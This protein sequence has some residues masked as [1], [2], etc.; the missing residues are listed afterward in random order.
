MI[1]LIAVFVGLLA[2]LIRARVK[3]RE[4]R[5]SDLRYPW[6]VL[7]AFIPQLFA[8][9]IPATSQKVS[10]PLAVII[11]VTTQALLLIFSVLNIK[12]TSFWPI[13]TGF[14]ANF[15]VILLNGGLMPISPATITKMLPAG[16]ANTYPVGERLGTGKDIVLNEIDTR[17]AFLSDRIVLRNFLN[18]SVAFSAGDI[19]I[20]LGVL[21]LLWS[22][23]G[24]REQ[25]LLEKK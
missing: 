11:L 15:M 9:Y 12:K 13:I 2:G 6:L 10:D 4:Y 22:M 16:A 25:V 1:L 14:F 17:L 24:L 21:W 8:F 23:G 3:K 18:A 19:L 5:Y 20:A 7:A